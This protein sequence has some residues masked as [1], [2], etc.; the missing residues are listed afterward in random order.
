MFRDDARTRMIQ[1][2]ADCRVNAQYHTEDSPFRMG[3][4]PRVRTTDDYL[5]EREAQGRDGDGGKPNG[6]GAG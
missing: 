1:M 2:C 4:R 5:A 3:E 6:S